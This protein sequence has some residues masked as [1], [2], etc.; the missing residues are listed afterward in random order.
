MKFTRRKMAVA[1][2]APA[3]LRSL[4]AQAPPAAAGPEDLDAEAREQVRKNAE[5]MAKFD[6]PLSTEPAFQF[7][8]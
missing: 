1:V 2:F 3:A 4:H 5:A 7:K 8:A 6:L